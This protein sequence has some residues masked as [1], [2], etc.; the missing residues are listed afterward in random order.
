MV[1]WTLLLFAFAG[2]CHAGNTLTWKSPTTGGDVRG[3]VITPAD[4][5]AK[6]PTVVVLK[7]IAA[8]RV[9]TESG[10]TIVDDF[11]KSG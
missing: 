10:Q 4:A 2:T 3:E 8:P 11:A 6:L 1:R 7:N 9:G 5:G